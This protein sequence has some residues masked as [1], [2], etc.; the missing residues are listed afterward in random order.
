MLGVVFTEFMEMV[1]D[2]FSFDVADE[3]MSRAGLEDAAAYTAVAEYDH[4]DII[5][6]VVALHQVTDIEIDDLVQAFGTHLFERFA[7][8]Y[9]ELFSGVSSS[10]DFL[11][12]VEGYIH[13][14]VRK[15]YPNAQLPSFECIRHNSDCLEMNYKSTRP[16]GNLAHGLIVG[17]GHHFRESLEVV[18][19]KEVSPSEICFTI[20]RAV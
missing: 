1:E 11:E 19:S 17:C 5:K 6:L 18:R 16:F 4:N 10:L 7:T 8:R 2:K 20:T 14:E 12:R 9:P 13:V 15:L 3:I